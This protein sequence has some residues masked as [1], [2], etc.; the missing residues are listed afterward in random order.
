MYFFN[1]KRRSV[2]FVP[3][4][5]GGNRLGLNHFPAGAE[6]P[7]RSLQQLRRA[8]TVRIAALHVERQIQPARE[9]WDKFGVG[10][11]EAVSFGSRER[12]SEGVGF[13]R[14]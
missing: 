9:A 5:A 7:T 13:V 1:E 14:A 11:R 12:R 10:L 4:E 8:L 3:S 6:T 2:E